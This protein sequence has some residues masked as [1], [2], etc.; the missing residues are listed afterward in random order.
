MGDGWMELLRRLVEADAEC[1][2][3]TSM[4]DPLEG[5]EA[6]TDSCFQKEEG[7]GTWIGNGRRRLGCLRLYSGCPEPIG[8][9]FGRDLSEHF[10]YEL[11]QCAGEYWTGQVVAEGHFYLPQ[12]SSVSAEHA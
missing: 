3:E 10:Q 5:G 8:Q 6:R 9:L 11:V 2:G 12:E 4:G 7:N 1:S